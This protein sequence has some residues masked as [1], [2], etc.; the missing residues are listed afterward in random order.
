MI[1]SETSTT[2]TRATAG[3]ISWSWGN[4]LDSADLETVTGKSSN[5]RLGTW[6][7]G[8]LHD[9]TLTTDLDV[10]GV[11]TNGLELTANV[12]SSQHGGVWRG[13][14]SISLDLHT[15]GD[16]GVGFTAGQISDVDESVGTSRLDVA[17]TESAVLVILVGTGGWWSVVGLLLLLLSF[18]ILTLLTLG[19]FGL[20]MVH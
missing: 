17:N 9:T 10:N 15:T 1:R 13:L 3:G 5:G 18:G 19:S 16:S 4:I 2:A 20:Y 7:W 14:F 12:D 6:T 8:L 11:D